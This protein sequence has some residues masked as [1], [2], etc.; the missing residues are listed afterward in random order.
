[1]KTGRL[2]TDEILEAS[3]PAEQSR[4]F[5]H[6]RLLTTLQRKRQSL[7][8]QTSLAGNN[9][10]ARAYDVLHPGSDC[11]IGPLRGTLPHSRGL[12]LHRVPIARLFEEGQSSEA[13]P[14]IPFTIGRTWTELYCLIAWHCGTIESRLFHLYRHTR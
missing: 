5:R 2:V 4:A 6:K 1:M 3:D 14:G 13:Y 8:R 9:A 10:R 11:S 7:D 12:V